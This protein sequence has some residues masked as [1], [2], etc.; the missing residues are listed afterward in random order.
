MRSSELRIG[1]LIFDSKGNVLTIKAI[2]SKE[3]ATKRDSRKRIGGSFI[4]ESLKPIPLTEEWL[5][6]FGFR[7]S[8]GWFGKNGIELFNINNLY[9]RGNFPIKADI[10]YIHQLQNLYFA[11]CGEELQLLQNGL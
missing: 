11:L 3:V 6:K 10:K 4:L 7:Y 1:N 9:F 5:M 2:N 8:V